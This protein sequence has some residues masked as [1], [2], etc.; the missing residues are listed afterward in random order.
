[1]VWKIELFS[2]FCFFSRNNLTYLSYVEILVLS[3]LNKLC[4]EAAPEIKRLFKID[5]RPVVKP[6]HDYNDQKHISMDRVDM[7]IYSSGTQVRSRPWQNC[8]ISGRRVHWRME[9]RQKTLE[10]VKPVVSMSDYMHIE[11]ILT[12]GCPYELNF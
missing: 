7:A 4:A 9:E 11:K 5:R 12:S 1:M 8:Q 2:M 10:A 3:K 6:G